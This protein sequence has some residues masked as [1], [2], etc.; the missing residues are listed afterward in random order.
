[1]AGEKNLDILLSEMR[2]ALIDGVFVFCTVPPE[3]SYAKLEPELMFREDEGVTLVVRRD[4]AEQNNIPYQFPSRK[5]SI[6]IH[7]SLEAVGLMAA[8]ATSLAAE[9]ISVNPV[10]AYYHDHLFVPA[11]RAEDALNALLRLSQAKQA[12][13]VGQARTLE[14]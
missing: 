10:S 4:C 11:D 9:K 14:V 6:L 1:M 5:I 3:Y 2:P 13:K 12:P 7:S 8:L